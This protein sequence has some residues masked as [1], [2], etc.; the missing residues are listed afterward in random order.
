MVVET[1]DCVPKY[2]L[3]LVS[4]RAAWGRKPSAELYG[5]RWAVRKQPLFLNV[6]CDSFRIWAKEINCY[7]Q[8][9][10]VKGEVGSLNPFSPYLN[11]GM[12]GNGRNMPWEHWIGI[13][14]SMELSYGRE[15][16]AITQ[17]AEQKR[18]IHVNYVNGPVSLWTCKAR[19][20]VN[21]PKS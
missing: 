2:A 4:Y 5:Y 19:L 10:T 20:C 11:N 8:A 21:P 3:S 13:G 9:R 12:A 17:L 15:T 7:F 14:S 1:F 16:G 18:D 6:L